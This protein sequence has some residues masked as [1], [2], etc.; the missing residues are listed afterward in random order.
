MWLPFQGCSGI[1]AGKIS[2]SITQAKYSAG[3]FANCTNT[4]HAGSAHEGLCAHS[5]CD[6]LCRQY[7]QGLK[8]LANAD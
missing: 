8:D 5:L 3:H 7:V 6:M 4:M 1:A 2:D